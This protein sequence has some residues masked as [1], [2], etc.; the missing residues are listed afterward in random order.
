MAWKNVVR[1]EAI[2]KIVPRIVMLVLAFVREQVQ[3]DRE[4]EL[5]LTIPLHSLEGKY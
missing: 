2:G 5:L 4:Q 1:Q 3:M